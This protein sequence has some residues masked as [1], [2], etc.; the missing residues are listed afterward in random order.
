MSV[1]VV[2]APPLILL[3]KINQ[4]QLLAKL[5]GKVGIPHD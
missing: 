4:L 5:A 2:N 1:W 3:G